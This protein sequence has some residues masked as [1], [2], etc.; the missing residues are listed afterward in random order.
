M[1]NLKSLILL[2]A[3]LC[4]IESQAFSQGVSINNSNTPPDP[5]AM[6]DVQSVERGFLPPRMSTAQRQSISNPADGLLVFDVDMQSLQIFAGG[7][8]YP[9]QTGDGSQWVFD[10]VNLFFN[11]GKV[12]VGTTNPRQQLSVGSHLDLYSGV[13]NSPSTPS[14]RAS[15]GNDLLINS[16]G[17]GLLIFNADG[18]TGETRFFGGNN[19][20]EMMRLSQSGNLGIGVTSPQAQLH[21]DGTIRSN[22]LAGNGT[23]MLVASGDGTFYAQKHTYSVGDLA[24]GGVVFWVDETGQHGLVCPIENQSEGVRWL[25]GEFGDTQAKGD[26]PFAGE[27][28]TAIIIAAQVYLGDDG[29][30]Y[31]ARICNELQITAG[32]K[33]YGDWYLPS[34]REL[35]LLYLN[36]SVINE[37]ALANGGETFG[38]GWFWS[39]TEAD[40]ISVN[41]WDF[42][43]GIEFVMGKG[44]PDLKVRAVRAF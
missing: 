10:G 9:L 42:Q 7:N 23:R 41:C 35:E 1:S 5:S 2:F 32:G 21:L 17:E 26:G 11:G 39:S 14:I 15:Q 19:L 8:W 22:N 18:G 13:V 20:N 16:F 31:A 34:K 12:G 36:R 27:L 24:Q 38:G 6:L 3:I 33:T 40:A 4:I 29:D 28:N 43:Y 25:A 44:N 37:V 30:T